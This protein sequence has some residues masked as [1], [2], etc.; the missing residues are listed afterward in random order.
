MKQGSEGVMYEWGS[1]VRMD[2]PQ[3]KCGAGGVAGDRLLILGEVTWVSVHWQEPV[4][5]QQRSRHRPGACKPKYCGLGEQG[6][7]PHLE[8][9]L[10][11]KAF[12]LTLFRH[13]S[14]D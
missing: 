13:L 14:Q 7:T 12:S 6:V 3:M 5:S 9:P 11:I 1:C 8:T 10:M 4:L 2:H